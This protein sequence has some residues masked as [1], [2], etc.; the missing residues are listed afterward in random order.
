MNKIIKGRVWVF[1][2]SVNTDAMYPGHAM[3]L[4]YEEA[5]RFV[6]HELR[7]GWAAEVRDGDIVVAGRNFGVGSSRPVSKL[8]TV[9]GVSALIADEFNSLFYRNCI[10]YGLP[11]LTAPG[12]RAS[13]SDGDT[14]IVDIASGRVDN[15]TTSTR[16]QGPGLPEMLLDILDAGGLMPR[17]TRDGYLPS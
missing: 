14:A 6:F 7:P 2:D 16:L 1:G 4:P 10:N 8:F 5:A 9:L 13:F 3:R 15:L 17:L 12:A 11:A